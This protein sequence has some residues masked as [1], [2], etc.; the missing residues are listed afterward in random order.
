MYK[1]TGVLKVGLN[2]NNIMSNH[3]KLM[4]EMYNTFIARCYAV[5]KVYKVL[6]VIQSLPV[7]FMS[8]CLL[9]YSS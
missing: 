4:R 6:Y 3:K 2:N 9:L 1:K 8:I 5:A 7:G